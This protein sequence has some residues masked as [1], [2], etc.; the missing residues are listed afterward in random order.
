[1]NRKGDNRRRGRGALPQASGSLRK[2]ST[3][4]KSSTPS[5]V[6]AS[7]IPV[8]SKGA[9]ESV[10]VETGASRKST[11]SDH[12][13]QTA[14][15]AEAK[16]NNGNGHL[17]LRSMGTKVN[18]KDSGYGSHISA[19][20]SNNSVG[21]RKKKDSVEVIQEM[22]LSNSAKVQAMPSVP[23]T[24]SASSS[25]SSCPKISPSHS[26][27]NLSKPEVS[28]SSTQLE[29]VQLSS[30]K[31]QERQRTPSP[32]NSKRQARKVPKKRKYLPSESEDQSLEPCVTTINSVLPQP[33]TT[34]PISP[35]PVQTPTQIALPVN[36]QP[37]L[38]QRTLQPNSFTY[39][40]PNVIVEPPQIENVP[41][42]G[43]CEWKGHRVLANRNGI[44]LSGMIS[45][46]Q[47]SWHIVVLFDC[48]QTLLY[49]NDMLGMDKYNIIGDH[50]PSPGD[51]QNGT[52]VCARLNQDDNQFLQGTVLSVGRF[53]AQYEVQIDNSFGEESVK[54]VS[55]ANVRLMEPPWRDELEM[56]IRDKEMQI[57]EKEMQLREKEMQLQAV[58]KSPLLPP[59]P[60]LETP[61]LSVLES[62]VPC[63]IMVDLSKRKRNPE[64]DDDSS[65]DELKKEYI[66]F[67]LESTFD[68][69][70]DRS[71]SL[72][73]CS[74]SQGSLT[75]H[76]TSKKRD[77]MQSRGSSTSD[78]ISTPRSP[79]IT[80]QKLYKKGDVVAAPNGIRKK[81]NGKQWRRLCSKEGCTKE[82]QRRGYCSRHLSLKGKNL[83]SP[84]LNF[85][86]R[87]KGVLKDS[88][89]GREIE[90]EDTSR[91]SDISPLDKERRIAGRFD[92]DETE[93][94]NIMMSLGNSRSATPASISPRGQS[95]SPV[96]GL[97]SVRSHMFTPIVRPNLQQHSFI[98]SPTRH[99]WS[100]GST[101][102]PS[103]EMVNTDY[104]V[105]NFQQTIRPEIVRTMEHNAGE[106]TSA[107]SA[108]MS[109]IQ[110]HS[111]L[112]SVVHPPTIV[113][114]MPSQVP[115]VQSVIHS[116]ESTEDSVMER[117]F[118]SKL[119]QTIQQ[120]IPPNQSEN[121]AVLQ[122]QQ[123]LQTPAAAKHSE[124]PGS[125]DGLDTLFYAAQ[126]HQQQQP[127]HQQHIVTS[128]TNKNNVAS[129]LPM[130]SVNNDILSK[131][132]N[133]R[134]QRSVHCNKTNDIVEPESVAQNEPIQHPTPAHLL[135]LMPIHS[136]NDGRDENGF[137]NGQK[138]NQACGDSH[139][140]PVFPWHS[141]VPFLTNQP[142][143][144]PVNSAP[145][146]V[147]TITDQLL[148]SQSQSEIA[149]PGVTGDQED[150]DDDVFLS[151]SEVGLSTNPSKRRTQS[152]SA[153]PA[154][155]EPKS[156]RKVKDKDHIRRP[157]NAFMI[158][159]KRHRAL[160]HQR[161]P[162]QDNRTVS[163]ILGEWWYALKPQE[164]KKYH[165]LAYQVKE[166][167]FKAHPDWK[168]CSRDRKKSS[169]SSQS[170]ETRQR[171]SSTDDATN[172]IIQA[173]NQTQ[174][175]PSVPNDLADDKSK[176]QLSAGSEK[177]ANAQITNIVSQHIQNIVT[178]SITNNG[179][180]HIQMLPSQPNESRENALED[181]SDE[182]RMVIC[183]ELPT[184]DEGNN[185]PNCQPEVA[186]DLKCK[187]RVTDSDSDSMSEDEPL[188]E[189]KAFPQQRFSPVMKSSA[190]SS[191][192]YRPK[193]IK[194]KPTSIQHSDSAFN[195]PGSTTMQSGINDQAILRPLSS[196]NFQPTGSVFQ[197]V[198]QSPKK[199]SEGNGNKFQKSLNGS[200]IVA[201]RDMVMGHPVN[202]IMQSGNQKTVLMCSAT[203]ANSN[204]VI[205]LQLSTQ[206]TNIHPVDANHK[207]LG[208]EHLN[209]NATIFPTSVVTNTNQTKTIQS[210]P[211]M[212]AEKQNVIVDT[213]TNMAVTE[214]KLKNGTNKATV[215]ILNQQCNLGPLIMVTSTTADMCNPIACSPVITMNS[216]NV[217]PTFTTTFQTITTPVPIQL[218]NHSQAE[219]ANRTAPITAKTSV[220]Y[221]LHTSSAAQ[222]ASSLCK[223]PLGTII[224]PTNA[225]FGS[226]PCVADSQ[227]CKPS[228]ITVQTNSA[229]IPTSQASIPLGNP[230][231]TN[232]ILQTNQHL[233]A[234]SGNAPPTLIPNNGQHQTVASRA[235]TQVQQVQYFISPVAL[236]SQ[237]DRKVSGLLP[238]ALSTSS[239]SPTNIHLTFPTQMTTSAPTIQTLTPNP[240]AN[241]GKIQYTQVP[242]SAPTALKVIT[243]TPVSSGTPLTPT[244]HS[245]SIQSVIVN[246]QP[247]VSVIAHQV[248]TL[249]PTGTQ[250]QLT[251]TTQNLTSVSTTNAPAQQ[252]LLSPP[253]RLAY[254]KQPASPQPSTA[255]NKIPKQIYGSTKMAG[256]SG[257]HNQASSSSGGQLT[258]GPSCHL[259][260]PI[261]SPVVSCQMPLTISSPKVI[262]AL[263]TSN[264]QP[265]VT[266]TSLQSP[267]CF[268]G[269]PNTVI[270]SS[271][272]SLNLEDIRKDGSMI[273][274]SPRKVFH[275]LDVIPDQRIKLVSSDANEG[276][277]L[278]D[279]SSENIGNKYYGS[280]ESYND[281][282]KITENR[283]G[284]G[285]SDG[286]SEGKPQRSCKGKRYKEMVVESGLI[287]GKR[288]RKLQSVKISGGNN[289]ETT[290]DGTH[291]QTPTEPTSHV[292]MGPPPDPPSQ[293]AQ[294]ILAPTPAQLGRAPGQLNQRRSSNGTSSDLQQA[295][296]VQVS[297]STPLVLASSS[298][299]TPSSGKDV[300][301]SPK[302]SILK[303]TQDGGMEKVLE[304]VNFEAR[305]A[306][307]PEFKPEECQSPSALSL[308]NSP[309]AFVQSYRKKR[310]PSTQDDTE[311]EAGSS[312][313]RNY[314]SSSEAG[315]PKTPRSAK[316]EGTQFF[317][318][319]FN[320]DTLH[321]NSSF[322]NDY[323]D[324]DVNSPRSPRT[325]K[326]PKDGEKGVHSS[327][328][329]ILDQRRQLV[330]QL[331]QEQG[332]F[333][334]A[335]ATSAFQ[336]KHAD[337]FNTRT[338]LQL[339]IREVR[340]KLM[341][342]NNSVATTPT[343][344]SGECNTSGSSAVVTLMPNTFSSSSPSTST[345]SLSQ[346][347]PMSTSHSHAVVSVVDTTVT[348]QPALSSSEQTRSSTVL[349]S[350]PNIS[351]TTT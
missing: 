136:T 224:I 200:F 177:Q 168:W 10:I 334:S 279:S 67:P 316:F 95:Q 232:L 256:D 102:C 179:Q 204:H 269:M 241:N 268:K 6:G 66:N 142:S 159:S 203:I 90:W 313:P 153:L 242:V 310:K 309:R 176:D 197:G 265:S 21:A 25:S 73:P 239:G 147:S 267:Y 347:S 104:P 71:A 70:L 185:E 81:F 132:Y 348:V 118:N 166:A 341:S 124:D 98:A 33:T 128:S 115:N 111:S 264:T 271:S 248:V 300:P 156:P 188:I 77:S 75:P 133:L 24:M 76:Q 182:E 295:A 190:A 345:S 48:D 275:S 281:N 53:R 138:G 202:T 69:R 78:R 305:F 233:G 36:Q 220:P 240:Q 306:A 122:Q 171:L 221:T 338:C 146:S 311:S 297:S 293:Q 272:S 344:V 116:V 307:L 47:D 174:G 184:C 286:N 148:P 112:P 149:G 59:P 189:N 130:Q 65:E 236:P 251:P 212:M 161:H 97:L 96:A 158:F 312:K 330:M 137:D 291:S 38:E 131:D 129:P 329:R 263:S 120:F 145:P 86:G 103:L 244:P 32:E 192:T 135:P 186:I 63:S 318:P 349:L 79:A 336:A 315:T 57:R 109:L 206:P 205:P 266:A 134:N 183:D 194:A 56:L 284:E 201:N 11:R 342:Q 16:K 40:M 172:I 39:N 328:R 164:K 99:R 140:I 255:I 93:A 230:I 209:T 323:S 5:T 107:F 2:A 163:K 154:K 4:K 23:T 175:N 211:L 250:I 249:T 49:Y 287:G 43:L 317:G 72:T 280:S 283:S 92:M 1:M 7:E 324:S 262:K 296:G 225:K 94:A 15:E 237:G 332:L 170:K 173:L 258:N 125:T 301:P 326:T 85:P 165:D 150:G 169:T 35:V 26:S 343:T 243:G 234:S 13:L 247:G 20:A 105:N 278:P 61:I 229:S 157:M 127:V 52:R 108:N 54:W 292:C 80:P 141:L 45:D 273:L 30:E 260:P 227:S 151:T 29:T 198:P 139:P 178:R 320:L 270:T 314:S 110:T 346:P 8:R 199:R 191:V 42:I 100:S 91:E 14:K 277:Q 58:E 83:R 337:I 155:D 321:E 114:C 64:S 228:N 213:R 68:I 215:K 37:L 210:V 50:S 350:E 195:Y 303:K 12:R 88:A 218:K 162:N 253:T 152:L 119:D 282:V 31:T 193:P 325:P 285:K 121:H 245:P 196:S 126:Q 238:V 144:S 222:M 207:C 276:C 18:N 28:F 51:I 117:S 216:Q 34:F 257:Q 290:S 340:Q 167:H 319:D 339:K 298:K 60:Q 335:Q 17:G 180:P 254:V 226:I 44:Y 101:E 333:P 327:L 331:F 246:K 160:V 82:S 231:F 106:T 62:P 308:P 181:N 223:S 89:M 19:T 288:D 143:T 41:E 219:A 322:R 259:G 3:R 9:P 289:V 217:N 74:Q 208:N 84:T 55:R 304:E 113:T 252:V 299:S 261:L 27:P 46:V 123:T 214:D 87:R 235:P 187:E 22:P 294:F 274:Q 351:N 302:K